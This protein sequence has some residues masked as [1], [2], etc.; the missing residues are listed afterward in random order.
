[1]TRDTF[2]G[3]CAIITL[4]PACGMAVRRNVARDA[5]FWASMAAGLMGP[6][7][8][9]VIRMDGVWRADLSTTLW[10]TVSASMVVFAAVSIVTREGWRL[11][12][13]TA[14]YLLILAV[15]ALLWQN[16]PGRLL[17]GSGVWILIHIAVSIV[18]YALVT[19]GAVAALAAFILERA[20]K[21]KRSG[22][23]SRTLPSVADCERL[24]VQLLVIGEAVLGVGLVSGMAVHWVEHGG[25]LAFDHKTI[26]TIASFVVIGVLLVLHYRW[27][28]RGRQAARLVLLG[29]LLLTLGYPG[30]K[31][32]ADVILA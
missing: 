17:T 31:F 24:V 32:V 18:T 7:T 27:G 25:S 22:S 21:E 5:L 30:V 3:I 23:I 14:N 19:I 29:Y 28:V 9:S 13:L 6:I 4:L 20:L 2:L 26:L 1:M 10:V 8:W 16:S 11:L 15:I 12:P